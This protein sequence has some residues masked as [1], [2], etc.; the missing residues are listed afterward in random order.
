V[1]EYLKIY[2]L[3]KKE[4]IMSNAQKALNFET[5]IT[6]EQGQTLQ[7]L[8]ARNLLW[9]LGGAIARHPVTN[10]YGLTK[11][12]I[13]E[14]GEIAFT[15]DDMPKA[16]HADLGTL[17]D[18][19]NYLTQTLKE[20]AEF[21]DYDTR[22]GAPTKPF[23]WYEIPSLEFY[24]RNFQAYKAGRVNTTRQDQAK[25]LGIKT[26]VPLVDVSSEV[27]ELVANAMQEIK[28]VS[29]FGTFEDLQTAIAE[30]KIDPLYIIHQSAVGMLDRAKASL[31]AGK[32]GY[33][34]PEIL[35]FARW[36]CRP[37]QGAQAPQD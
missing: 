2:H 14:G 27:T 6:G 37:Q 4:I 33:I 36:T 17:V 29:D 5:I 11:E 26:A 21:E 24:I 20:L 30:M 23:A 7:H 1:S 15:P 19:F 13:I 31:M 22:T 8:G 18:G 12:Q 28:G 34:D 10:G 3:L 16:Q 35:A 25:A 9:H 32:A